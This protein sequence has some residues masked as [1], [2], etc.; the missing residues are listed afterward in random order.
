MDGKESIEDLETDL[1]LEGIY[2]RF[3]H[4]YRGYQRQTLKAKL[5]AL[6]QRIG[7]ETVSGLLEHVM[8]DAETG[9]R[10]LH[11]LSA[12][13]PVFFDDPVYFHALRETVVPWLR[14]CPSPRVWVA[15]CVS[16]ED[17]AA[18]AILLAEEAL[19]DRTQIFATAENEALLR[20]ASAYSFALDRLPKYEN[21]S[22]KSGGKARLA[23]YCRTEYGRVIFSPQLCSN[24]TWAQYSLATDASFNEFQLIVCRGAV[25]FSLQIHCGEPGVV[26]KSDLKEG[27]AGLFSQSGEMTLR[28]PRP[29]AR[30]P[31][32]PR[33][34]LRC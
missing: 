20:E 13:P 31:V 10:L 8:H 1:L 27:I 34:G 23:D 30:S 17:V 19:H 11:A 24:I 9:D 4:D 32:Q 14:S 33:S 2:R 21:A 28:L 5:Q 12:R 26:Q 25:R 29:A 3:G 15:E 18:L 22:R 16:A 7:V 6:M